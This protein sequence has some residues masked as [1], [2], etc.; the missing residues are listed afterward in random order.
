MKLNYWRHAGD[1]NGTGFAL[2]SAI[3]GM[4]VLGQIRASICM[5]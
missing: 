3:F 4:Y 1:M 2:L 5:Y